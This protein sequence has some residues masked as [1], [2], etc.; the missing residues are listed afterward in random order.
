VT[1]LERVSFS[2]ER[3]LL[4]KLERLLGARGYTN[5]SEFIR[6]MIRERLV[7]EEWRGD[8]EALGTIT[9]VYDHHARGL[10]EHLTELQHDH[11]NAILV[12]THLHLD[13]HLCAEII[14]A[15]GSASSLRQIAHRLRHHKGVLHGE[16]S[17]SSTGKKLL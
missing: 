2:I 15:R 7:E 4:D 5:R 16:L 14:V 1:D 17:M 11:H 3:P 9:L 6:D 10:H 13:R 8:R 12:S